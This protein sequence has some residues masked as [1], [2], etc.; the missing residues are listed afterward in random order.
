MK[1]LHGFIQALEVSLSIDSN[2]GCKPAIPQFVPKNGTYNCAS[3]K[4]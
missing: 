4:D 1:N 3:F 2:I